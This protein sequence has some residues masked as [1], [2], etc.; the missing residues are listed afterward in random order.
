MGG[1]LI[2]IGIQHFD[3]N[4]DPLNGGLLYSF[5][6]GTSTPLAIYSDQALTTP[7][8]NPF[9]L[10]ASG[11]IVAYIQDGIAYK[12]TLKTSAGV[13]ISGYPIDNISVPDIAAPAAAAEVPTGSILPYGGSTAPTGYLLCDG[14][15]VSRSQYA[16]L[17]AILSTAYG[18]GNGSTTFNLPDLRQRFPLGKSTSGTGAT[19]GSTGGTIDHSHAGPSH[20]HGPS[21][22]TI[23]SSGAHTHTTGAPIET[24]ADV[25]NGSGEAAAASP[26]T[27]NIAS[28]G[29]H[30]HAITGT[31]DAGGTG[32]TGTANPPFS[33]VTYVVKT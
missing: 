5:A 12:F 15:A 3:D 32:N 17:F 26:H 28:S 13:V 25:Q 22:L 14:S 29:A 20:S 2:P 16:A 4:G 9:A 27:H 1:F 11:R 21:L 24:A 6:A 23:A 33:T 7:M 18:V 10:S 19:L 8:S 30:V 31:T